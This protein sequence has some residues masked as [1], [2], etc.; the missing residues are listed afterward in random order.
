VTTNPDDDITT[1][2]FPVDPSQNNS[3]NNT[4]LATIVDMQVGFYKSGAYSADWSTVSLP[5]SP[6]DGK[7]C[8]RVNS[9]DGNQMRT[10][11]Y[12]GLKASWD[13]VEG[14]AGAT[15][16]LSLTDI[17]SNTHATIDTHLSSSANPH[18]VTQSQ[19][20]L[21]NVDNVADSDQTSLGI[22]TVGDIDGIANY[23]AQRG[24]D[25]TPVDSEVTKSITS[26][27]AYDHQNNPTDIKHLTDVQISALHPIFAPG[28]AVAN[29]SDISKI[30]QTLV[31]L[32]VVS[33]YL[34]PKE[35]LYTI[36]II[37]LI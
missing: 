35:Q 31:M 28:T 19:V 2:W 23:I 11:T 25:D 4:Y 10:Y 7:W 18:G 17:G 37:Q 14:G 5:A 27:W 13:T 29:H 34:M 3:S 1:Y 30:I 36:N 15:S 32:V 6:S 26:N 8:I 24:I 20:G 12:N 33:L 16:H 9:D 21:S 22:V